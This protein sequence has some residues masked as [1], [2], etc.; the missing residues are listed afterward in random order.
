MKSSENQLTEESKSKSK[1]EEDYYISVQEYTGQG[2]KLPNGE[3]TDKIA[4]E[5]RKEIDK[6]VKKFFQEKYKTEV[7]VHNTV[8]AVDGATVFV[9]SVGEPHFYTYAI[10]P[11]DVDEEEVLS[12]QVW[13]QEGEVENAIMA[14]VY[15][16]IYEEEFNKL[17]QYLDSIVKEHPVTGIRQEALEKVAGGKFSTPYYYVNAIEYEFDALLKEYL[18]NPHMEKATWKEKFKGATFNPEGLLITLDLYM[19]K[20]NTEPDKVIFD[21]IVSDIKNMEGLPSGAYSI[22]LN[23]NLISKRS[24]RG[25]KDNSLRSADPD[26]IIK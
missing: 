17:D 23:D 5:Y 13:S 2:Y 9:E 11:I 1:V 21:K 20:P 22:I 16:M 6:A 3:K 8:G 25:T 15:G 24:A 10:I 7:I 19:S 12:D 18:K 14:G 26:Y 4:K